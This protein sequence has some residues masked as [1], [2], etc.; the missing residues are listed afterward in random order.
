[1]ARYYGQHKQ[2]YLAAAFQ[3]EKEGKVR[4]ALPLEVSEHPSLFDSPDNIDPIEGAIMTNEQPLQDNKT[5]TDID[6]ASNLDHTPLV[7][8]KYNGKTP[9]Q[10]AKIDP[11]WL[12][13]AFNN[14]KNRQT[15]SQL[16]ANECE[17]T[18]AHRKAA[19][20]DKRTYSR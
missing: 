18:D 19:Q 7:F 2:R 11:G 17:K 15:C 14:V 3:A 12:V 20:C 13:W 6:E 5:L 1:M 10:V 4:D 8:G 16:L 9:D